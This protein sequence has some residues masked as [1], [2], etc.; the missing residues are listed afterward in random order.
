MNQ[1]CIQV[2]K[3]DFMWRT[4]IF[5]EKRIDWWS[6]T[7]WMFLSQ[8]IADCHLIIPMHHHVI[9]PQDPPCIGSCQE[10]PSGLDFPFFHELPKRTGSG[11]Y[12][13]GIR[14][15]L[16]SALN[17]LPLMKECVKVTFNPQVKASL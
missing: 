8:N 7:G 4:C 6:S 13:S 14:F 3:N 2:V 17:A 1:V 5:R 10:I 9:E 15:E 12:V 11:L 16:Q